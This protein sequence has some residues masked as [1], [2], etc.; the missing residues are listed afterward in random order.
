MY[1]S[2]EDEQPVQEKL[3][4]EEKSGCPLT[5]IASLPIEEMSTLDESEYRKE[6]ILRYEDNLFWIRGAH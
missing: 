5:Q 6:L 4:V 3:D 2:N 1:A